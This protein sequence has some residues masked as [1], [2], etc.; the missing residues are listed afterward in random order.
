MIEAYGARLAVSAPDAEVLRKIVEGLPPGWR[1][2]PQSSQQEQV[3]WRISV[4]RVSE[5]YTLENS[6]GYRHSCDDLDLAIWMLRTQMRRQ[7]G[8]HTDEFVFIH[9]GVVAYNDRAILIPG[10]SFAGKSTLVAALVRAGATYYSDEFAM[11]NPQ[12]LV[13]QYRDPLSLRGPNGREEHDIGAAGIQEPIPVGLVVL[14]VY[15]PGSTWSPSTVTTGAG[16]VAMMEH[17]VPA[18]ERPG[19]TIATL[20]LAIEHAVIL[21]GDRGDADETAAA[22][23]AALA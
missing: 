7:V 11:L 10:P 2:S 13:A 17:A 3:P 18:R 23:L 21:Q 12:G 14:T 22:L 8:H 9:S 16:L 1:P 6:D 20:R 19:E 15:K 5:G 4:V